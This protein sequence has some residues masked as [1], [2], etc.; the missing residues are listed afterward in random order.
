[1]SFVA[2]AFGNTAKNLTPSSRKNAPLESFLP[3][4]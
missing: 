1:M 4:I 3:D 2:L